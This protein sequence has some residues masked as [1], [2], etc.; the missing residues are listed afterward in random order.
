[1]TFFLTRRWTPHYAGGG[2]RWGKHPRFTLASDQRGRGCSQHLDLLEFLSWQ[3]RQQ[4]VIWSQS[5]EALLEVNIKANAPHR[6]NGP[7]EPAEEGLALIIVKTGGSP[8]SKDHGDS[9][10]LKMLLFGT[11]Q[12]N[13]IS[14]EFPLLHQSP[15][16]ADVGE[17]LYC[18]LCHRFEQCLM[19][20][21]VQSQLGGDQPFHARVAGWQDFSSSYGLRALRDGWS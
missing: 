5:H 3:T 19:Q 10:C 8:T 6:S 2:C 9:F 7:C 18:C 20:R 21:G 14:L 1:M 16:S 13:C 4:A 15:F 12:I 17:K 11:E